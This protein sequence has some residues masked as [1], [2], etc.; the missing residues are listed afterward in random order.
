[1]SHFLSVFFSFIKEGQNYSK[2]SKPQQ[3][4]WRKEWT[5]LCIKGHRGQAE[6]AE[7]AA[8][9]ITHTNIHSHTNIHHSLVPHEWFIFTSTCIYTF[10]VVLLWCVHKV[11]PWNERNDSKTIRAQS[12]SVLSKILCGFV[13]CVGPFVSMQVSDRQTNIFP[14]YRSS[15]FVTTIRSTSA[16]GCRSCISRHWK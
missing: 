14:L 11:L 15:A 10:V 6:D 12:Y 3:K 9:P 2:E 4:G 1:M 8:A 13:I 7:D 16:P 5:V